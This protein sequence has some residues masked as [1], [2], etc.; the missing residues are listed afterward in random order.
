MNDFLT[1]LRLNA[2]V[3]AFG[4]I[5]F[6]YTIV[7]LKIG[8]FGELGVDSQNQFLT[9]AVGDDMQGQRLALNSRVGMKFVAEFLCISYEAVLASVSY[10]RAWTYNDWDD[11]DQYWNETG[12]GVSLQSLRAVAALNGLSVTSASATLQSRDYLEQYAR[13][14]G[15][16]QAR[17]ALFSL[18]T[19]ENNGLANLQTNAN[20]DSYPE[21]SDDGQILAYISDSSSQS[22]YESRVHVS[23]LRGS[24][25]ETS[26]PIANPNDGF[27]GFGDSDVD[28]AGTGS[29]AAAAWVRLNS[30]IE[31]KDA[32]SQIDLADQNTLMN[33]AEIVVSIYDADRWTSQRLTNNSAPDLAPAVAANGEKAIVFWRSVVSNAESTGDANELLTFEARDCLMYS[34]YNGSAWSEPAMLYNGSN[35]S[36][37]ALQ[38]AMLPDGTAIAVYTL[39]RSQVDTKGSYEIGY[40]VDANGN[41]GTTMLATSDTWLDENPQVVTA[42]FGDTDS[43]FVIGWHSL[44]DDESDIQMLAVSNDG[45]MS[46]DFPSSLTSLIRDGSA[47]VNGDF[48]FASMG[49]NS[50]IGNLTIIWSETITDDETTEGLTVAAHSELKAAKLLRSS[51]DARYRLSSPLELAELP[52]NNLVNHFSAYLSGD[53]VKAVIQATEYSN[54]EGNQQTIGWGYRPRRADQTLHRHLRFPA[55]RGGSGVHRGGL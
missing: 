3:K 13:T 12:T 21:I 19:D 49:G 43:R 46:N 24:S 14:W 55:V 9:R 54:A 31:G 48:R 10:N 22:I 6:D 1:N 40:T 39:D 27:T 32:G 51:E 28:I 8:L 30:K 16:P 2:Y 29:F 11:I 20:P 34:V 37:K 23:T 42:N 7:A 50:D 18:D 52:S 36:V 45:A 17:M 38:A 47:A 41:L 53:Q 26:S 25:Y 5:G 4:G 33:G 15:Q 44:R 35:G